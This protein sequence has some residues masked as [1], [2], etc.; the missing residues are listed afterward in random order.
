MEIKIFFWKYKG[1]IE[2]VKI[3]ILIKLIIRQSEDKKKL[4]RIFFYKKLERENG[5]SFKLFRW[6]IYIYKVLILSIFS[7]EKLLQNKFLIVKYGLILLYLLMF[8]F[9]EFL[10]R[11]ICN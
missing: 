7:G 1:F 3:K 5:Q 2:R 10:L 11:I 9:Q 6:N 8:V 4:F